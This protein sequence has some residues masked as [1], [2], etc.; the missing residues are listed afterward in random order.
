MPRPPT[1]TDLAD[2][3]VPW[4]TALRW[5]KLNAPLERGNRDDCPACGSRGAFRAYDDHGFCWNCRGYF[6]VTGLLAVVW[7][8]DLEDAALRALDQIGYVPLSFAHRWEHV[9]RE[10]APDPGQL[11]L[12]LVTWCEAACPEWTRRRYDKAVANRLARCLGLLPKVKTSQDAE[13]WLSACKQVMGRC[14]APVPA[15]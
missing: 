14:L 11:E 2:T 12:A 1:L 4:A 5:A 6:S 9:Q 8:M 7:E 3:H 15:K 13:T 10:I